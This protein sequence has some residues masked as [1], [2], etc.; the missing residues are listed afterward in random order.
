[1]LSTSFTGSFSIAGNTRQ[2]HH[3]N[4]NI[5]IW[6]TIIAWHLTLQDEGTSDQNI[7]A[8]QSHN[9]CVHLYPSSLISTRFPTAAGVAVRGSFLGLRQRPSTILLWP[10]LALVPP[11]MRISALTGLQR[12]VHLIRRN[13]KKCMLVCLNVYQYRWVYVRARG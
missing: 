7:K 5:P 10:P 1:M 6:L 12:A 13:K 9:L 11:Y 3:R 8:Q 4:V 2:Q